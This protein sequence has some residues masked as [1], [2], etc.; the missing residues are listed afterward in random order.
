MFEIILV[1]IIAFIITF[2]TVPMAINSLKNKGITIL[3]RYKKD[4]P[5]I[6]TQGAVVII[7]STFL[8]ITFSQ[9]FN[10]YQLNTLDISILLVIA[11]FG[12]Y[13]L[14][15][16]LIDLGWGI[17]VILPLS[18]SFPLFAILNPDNILI[19]FFGRIFISDFTLGP[20]ENLGIDSL[21]I[22]RIAV[23]SV[24][25]MVVVNLVNM[26]S[27]FNGLQ[28]GISFILLITVLTKSVIDEKSDSIIISASFLGGILAFWL[29]NKYPSRIIE[30]N[31]GS[32]IFGAALGTLIIIK[33]YYFFGIFILIPH[34][35]DFLLWLYESKV[36]KKDFNQ[37]KFGKLREDGTISPPTPMKLKFL[38][39]FY[40]DM[41]ESQIVL[42]LYCLTG[43]FCISGLILF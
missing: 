8:T 5:K 13:G 9:V 32:S 10:F 24:Y 2:S 43:I 20:L 12:L 42:V 28:S 14:V 26:H 7:F 39:L 11:M 25:L 41:K 27:G 38:F 23:I 22:F 35:F 4:K 34:I 21:S 37:V 18:F 29:F 40:F 17:K 1:F 31:I 16:D 30:G 33:E 3:D 36:L 19:P 15:D 6:P